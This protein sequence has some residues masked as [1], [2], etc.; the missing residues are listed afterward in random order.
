MCL[1]ILS[2]PSGL[3]VLTKEA[4]RMVLGTLLEVLPRNWTPGKAGGLVQLGIDRGP[5]CHRCCLSLTTF[6]N[7]EARGCLIMED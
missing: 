4:N 2:N 3:M 7:V 6:G 5:T 1:R